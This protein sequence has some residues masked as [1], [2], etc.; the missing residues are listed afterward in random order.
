MVENW[1]NL[2]VRVKYCHWR[3]IVNKNC[4][5]GI[6]SEDWRKY[7]LEKIVPLL[8]GDNHKIYFEVCFLKVTGY[9]FVRRAKCIG[10][11]ILKLANQKSLERRA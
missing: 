6:M 2:F 5:I 8:P 4:I 9:S 7:V 11:S 3:N 1:L 10:K